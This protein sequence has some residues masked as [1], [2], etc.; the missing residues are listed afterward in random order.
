MGLRSPYS[1]KWLVAT[2]PHE[3]AGGVMNLE[4]STKRMHK[5]RHQKLEEMS[6]V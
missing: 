1:V 6:F 4:I 3:P 5:Y 2:A